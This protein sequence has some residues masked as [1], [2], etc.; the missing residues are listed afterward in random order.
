MTESRQRNTRLVW[1]ET[2]RIMDEVFGHWGDQTE[3]HVPDVKKLTVPVSIRYT[4]MKE[5]VS[6]SSLDRVDGHWHCW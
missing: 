1:D 4:F 6:Y 2:N 3:V 5:F